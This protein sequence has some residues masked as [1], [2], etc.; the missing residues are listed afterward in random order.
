[1]TAKGGTRVLL[2]WKCR[3]NCFDLVTSSS[4]L[5]F[6]LP[7]ETKKTFWRANEGEEEEEEP[8]LAPLWKRRGWNWKCV[9]IPDRSSEGRKEGFG[10]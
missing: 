5:S 6:Q 4:R 8:F 7:R 9:A 10:R 1:M 3:K 2:A